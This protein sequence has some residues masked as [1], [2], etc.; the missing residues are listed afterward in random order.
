MLEEFLLN[1]IKTILVRLTNQKANYGRNHA[2]TKESKSI[3]PSFPLNIYQF[4][5][6]FGQGL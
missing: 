4:E 5:I 3:F 1:L 6:Y 2:Q